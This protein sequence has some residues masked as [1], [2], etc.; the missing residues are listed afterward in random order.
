MAISRLAGQ[1]TRLRQLRS[2]RDVL[3]REQAPGIGHAHF[4]GAGDVSRRP[5]Q[6]CRR[7]GRCGSH[8]RLLDARRCAGRQEDDDGR[9]EA[10]AGEPGTRRLAHLPA[11]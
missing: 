2:S 11:G 10:G 1:P 8:Q 9:T 6:R 3:Q 7:R 4:L 5:A